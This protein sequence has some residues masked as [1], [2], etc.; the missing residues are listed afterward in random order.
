[1]PGENENLTTSKVYSEM[2]E[3]EEFDPTDPEQSPRTLLEVDQCIQ[4]AIA[5]LETQWGY[6]FSQRHDDANDRHLTRTTGSDLGSRS[7]TDGVLF[8]PCT[9]EDTELVSEVFAER[10]VTINF[11]DVRHPRK[12][13]RGDFG[14]P[15]PIPHVGRVFT[16]TRTEILPLPGS[17]ARTQ[18][19]IKYCV[20][21]SVHFLLRSTE[22]ISVFF[23]RRDSPHPDGEGGSGVLWFGPVLLDLV[24]QRVVNGGILCT[25]FSNSY[26][27]LAERLQKLKVGE[28]LQ[29]RNLTLIRLEPSELSAKLPPLTVVQVLRT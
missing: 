16:D 13:V 2:E 5:Q 19:S 3:A 24:L 23:Y 11:C 7:L 21:D 8:Y 15:V 12:K 18:G 10:G 14:D 26:G 1:M 6:S 9:A 25:D 17:S 28:K 22:R 27:F 4:L 20:G 29:Y